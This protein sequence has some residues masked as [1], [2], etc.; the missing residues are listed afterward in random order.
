MIDNL[1]QWCIYSAK[2]AHSP[3]MKYKTN[4]HGFSFHSQNAFVILIT[5]NNKIKLS[6]IL[7]R[8]EIEILHR[9]SRPKSVGGRPHTTIGRFKG[10]WLR[11]AIYKVRNNFKNYNATM[12]PNHPLSVNEDLNTSSELL[13]NLRK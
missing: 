1:I 13:Y 7:Q 12:D 3:F 8:H 4:N 11:E 2:I 10:E 9:L 6:P 5:I